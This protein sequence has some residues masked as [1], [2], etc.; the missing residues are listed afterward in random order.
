MLLTAF[1]ACTAF[2]KIL[3][4]NTL[5]RVQVKCDWDLKLTQKW[6]FCIL[7]GLYIGGD[8]RKYSIIPFFF[9]GMKF[10]QQKWYWSYLWMKWYGSAQHR[11]SFNGMYNMWMHIIVYISTE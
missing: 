2:E 5:L 1:W 3:C 7:K 4:D 10:V 8:L 9:Y 6:E 11:P